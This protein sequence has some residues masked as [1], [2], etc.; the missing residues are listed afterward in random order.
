MRVRKYVASLSAFRSS[1]ASFPSAR[2]IEMI[3]IIV[4]AA[5]IPGLF[6]VH[7]QCISQTR[8]SQ[9]RLGGGVMGFDACTN[10]PLPK[11]FHAQH[12]DLAEP[13]TA[14]VF[15][16]S[17]E[18][19]IRRRDTWEKGFEVLPTVVVGIHL[20]IVRSLSACFA[21]PPT[22][23]SATHS[24]REASAVWPGTRALD[25]DMVFIL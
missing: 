10:T 12:S 3:S 1:D 23:L 16:W 17:E 9:T 14:T 13:T 15:S 5:P 24:R 7:C 21:L 19:G 6:A 18:L 22:F 11:G 8:I 25:C 2:R 20:C 4:R